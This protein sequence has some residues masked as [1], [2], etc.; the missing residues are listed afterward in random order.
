[1]LIHVRMILLGNVLLKFSF[2]L[3]WFGLRRDLCEIILGKCPFISPYFNNR[4][5]FGPHP[6]DDNLIIDM[7]GKNVEIL[8]ANKL[9]ATNNEKNLAT[10]NH[11]VSLLEP[12]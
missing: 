3:G 6:S 4:F 11:F 10:Q 9:P 7:T 1:M 5:K 12:D 2:Y 8:N